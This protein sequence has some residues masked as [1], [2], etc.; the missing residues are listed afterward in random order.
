MPL[1]SVV[2]GMHPLAGVHW[3]QCPPRLLAAAETL[4]DIKYGF[5]KRV[6]VAV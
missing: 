4:G 3:V 6:G 2:L 1:V 5:A